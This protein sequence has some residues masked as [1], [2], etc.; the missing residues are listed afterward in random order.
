MIRALKLIFATQKEWENIANANRGISWVLL[1]YLLPLMAICGY[2]E[3][4]GIWKLGEH[5]GEVGEVARIP[6]E[7]I[8]RYEGVSLGLLLCAIIVGTFLLVTVS[9]SFQV[10]VTLSQCFA[11]VG[12]SIGPLILIKLADAF[13]VINTWICYTVGMVFVA[14]MLYHGV[15][16]CLKPEQTKGFGIFVFS[17][18]FIALLTGL[19]HFVS[20][21][22]LRGRIFRPATENRAGAVSPQPLS[23]FHARFTTQP[24]SSSALRHNSGFRP[25]NS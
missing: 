1:T 11:A 8:F 10:P 3:G 15:A 17:V 18:V 22:V 21:L 13:P 20:T 23:F 24:D 6:L 14:S 16:N 5:R 4:Y 7:I 2:A 19:G 9:R 12:Y 25:V